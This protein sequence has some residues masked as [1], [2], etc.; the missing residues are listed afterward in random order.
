MSGL[1]GKRI[2]ITRA[3]GQV[4]EIAKHIRQRGG[5]PVTFPC[6]AVQC[7]PESI[8][9]SV[10]LL[11][12][13]GVHALFT[14]ANGV[15]CVAEALRDTFVSTFESV[16]VVTIGHH[17]AKAL[18]DMGVQAAW[19]SREASQE[20][21]M[22]A[23]RQRGLPARL[24]FFRAAQGRDALPEALKT[25]GVDVRLVPAYRTI[26]PDDDTTAVIELLKG[27]GVDAVL[28]GSSRTAQHYVRRIGDA[29]LANRPAIAVISAQVANTAHTMNLDVQV[30][31]KEASF[32]S[33]LDGLEE[34]FQKMT[35]NG[36]SHA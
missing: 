11:E 24:V 1:T 29:R 33:M 3:S 36:E 8:R 32:A 4:E 19:I 34:W 27:G 14:S 25:A 30:V 10:K 21:L 23:Y 31:A 26:C 20:G 16:P 7:C 28:L 2:L 13:D 17:T 18:S 5:M 35:A 6:L 9:Q 15:H 12:D 22:D